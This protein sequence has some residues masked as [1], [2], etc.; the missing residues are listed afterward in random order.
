MWMEVPVTN[1]Q[2][3]YQCVEGF[4]GKNWIFRGQS[5]AKWGLQSSF[6]REMKKAESMCGKIENHDLFERAMIGEFLSSAHLY[7]S[8]LPK[9]PEN[10][11]VSTVDAEYKLE[12]M[13]IMQHHGAPTR[14]L[15]WTFS[16][17][18]ASF[19]AVD[20]ATDEN[21]SVFALNQ[22]FIILKN[23]KLSRSSKFVNAILGSRLVEIE[24][25]VQPY[26][27]YYKNERLRRQQGLFLIPHPL[28]LTFDEIFTQ[29]GIS[30][31]CDN[32]TGEKVAIKFTFQKEIIKECWEKLRLMNLTHETIYP[33]L[34]GFCRSLKVG[35]TGTPRR[36]LSLHN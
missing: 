28:D 2:D 34:D 21:F 6:Y 23:R 27:T 26:E 20:G 32:E 14:L 1:W 33:G 22:D 15:D 10:E 29:Y 18:I 35:L 5:N 4:C 17:Y 30:D 13:S 36:R 11:E 8:H 9:P 12:V 7:S 31:G 3:F 19:F 24:P 25:F 16:P